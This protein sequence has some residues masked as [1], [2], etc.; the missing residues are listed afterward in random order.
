[1]R[2]NAQGAMNALTLGR[3]VLTACLWVAVRH[4]L[5]WTTIALI[6]VIMADI[7]DGVGARRLG[8]DGVQRRFLDAAVDRFSIHSVYAAA[9][10]V[11]P[12]YCAWYWPLLARDVAVIA[13]YFALVRPGGQIITGSSWHRWSSLSLALL[14]LMVVAEVQLAVTLAAILAI[15]AAYVLLADYCG[16][17]VAYRRGYIPA[18]WNHDGV[19]RSR[20]LKGIQTLIGLV[21]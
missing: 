15:T 8:V 19:I 12:Q 3:L 7:F 4:G 13:G 5:G 21:H 14:G 2:P 16:L 11:H 18:S 6:A 1:M 9:L 20:G 10:W 17:A